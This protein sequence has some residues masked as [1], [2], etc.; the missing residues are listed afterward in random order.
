L[1]TACRSAH[2]QGWPGHQAPRNQADHLN[3]SGPSAAII[4][5][6]LLGMDIEILQQARERP[7][8]RD[9]KRP[10]QDLRKPFALV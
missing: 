6:T 10:I 4:S 7:L 1:D 5:E 3:R 2:L 8:A 9:R